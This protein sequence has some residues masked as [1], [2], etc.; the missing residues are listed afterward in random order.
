MHFNRKTTA[1]N[2]FLDAAYRKVC[3]IHT[4]LPPGAILVFLTGR[5]EIQTLVKQLQ[6]K[7]A[8]NKKQSPHPPRSSRQARSSLADADA[9]ADDGDA[10]AGDAGGDD[11]LPDMDELE[12]DGDAAD[13][14][15][16]S[17]GSGG[18]DDEAATAAA[19]ADAAP[20]GPLASSDNDGAAPLL[21][22]T[23]L[24]LYAML[25]PAAQAAVFQ[26]PPAGHRLVR[27]DAS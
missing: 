4:K 27:S 23:V 24:P 26:P 25:S 1:D 2:D 5:R 16:G 7:F 21:P 8:P 19:A 13:S 11:E 10:T 9:T 18:E 20:L 15:D 6:T 22:V 17:S 12:A 14:D 3:Q